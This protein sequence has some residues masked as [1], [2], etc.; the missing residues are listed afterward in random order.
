MREKTENRPKE[1]LSVQKKNAIGPFRNSQ[2]CRHLKREE[3]R[4]VSQ[5]D[6]AI[7]RSNDPSNK[8]GRENWA[9]P[10]RLTIDN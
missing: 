9:N 10:R 2:M 6:F 3:A 7:P 4:P 5:M 8:G 1:A